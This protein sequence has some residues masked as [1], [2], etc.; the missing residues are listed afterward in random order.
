MYR[1]HRLSYLI[2]MP[3]AFKDLLCSSRTDEHNVEE[4]VLGSAHDGGNRFIC[5]L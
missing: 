4:G 2:D 3:R 5:C 1:K